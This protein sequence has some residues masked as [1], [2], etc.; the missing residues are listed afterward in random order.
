[1]LKKYIIKYNKYQLRFNFK[2]NKDINIISIRI[3]MRK[4]KKK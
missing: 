3:V 4:K 1:M 2:Q